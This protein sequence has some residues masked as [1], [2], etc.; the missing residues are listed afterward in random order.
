MPWQSSENYPPP[1][2]GFVSGCET[3]K[4][5]ESEH[6]PFELNQSGPRLA[7]H[8]YNPSSDKRQKPTVHGSFGAWLRS[9]IAVWRR[10]P[11]LA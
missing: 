4:R 10:A 11:S 3:L 5:R 8:T 7:G 2:F 1:I 6:A 9:Y